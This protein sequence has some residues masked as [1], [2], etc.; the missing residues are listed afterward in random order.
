MVV[1]PHREHLPAQTT[2]L[3]RS[4]TAK[5]KVHRNRNLQ[6]D[7]ETFFRGVVEVKVKES[8]CDGELLRF[9]SI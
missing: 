8:V 5:T 4:G 6:L 7:S 2:H 3:D 9:C 1:I